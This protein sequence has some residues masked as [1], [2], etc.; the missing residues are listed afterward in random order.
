MTVSLRIST[1]S[2]SVTLSPPSRMCYYAEWRH[3]ALKRLLS[4]SKI[5][6]SKCWMSG[7][8]F[9]ALHLCVHGCSRMQPSGQRSER[10]KWIHCFEGVTAI[11][12]CVA[13]SEYDQTLREDPTKVIWMLWCATPSQHTSLS[14]PHTQNRMEESLALWEEISNSQWFAKT[15]FI[16]FLNKLDL[17]KAKIKKV[18]MKVTF[19]DYTGICIPPLPPYLRPLIILPWPF[20]RR[21]QEEAW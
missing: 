3:R 14:H 15:A 6:L 10:R 1:A 2:C 21:V 16:L 8:T 17:F 7:V 9:H 5:S 18:D 12:F 20:L 11:I 13:M 4:I 19:P